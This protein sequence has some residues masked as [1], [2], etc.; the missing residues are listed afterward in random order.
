[1]PFTKLTLMLWTTDIKSTIEFY[2][3]ILDF[4]LDNYWCHLHKDE[5]SIMFSLCAN[6]TEAH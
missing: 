1:M 3:N 5:V 6:A 2:T 4:Q